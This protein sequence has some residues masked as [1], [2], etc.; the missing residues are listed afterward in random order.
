MTNESVEKVLVNISFS[1]KNGRI[2]YAPVYSDGTTGPEEDAG[3]DM[4][5]PDQAKDVFESFEQAKLEEAR[6][7]KELN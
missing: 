4:P 3:F 5:S 1:N 2:Y 6:G 7:V